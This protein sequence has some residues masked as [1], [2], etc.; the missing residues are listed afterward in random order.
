M[1][2]QWQFEGEARVCYSWGDSPTLL[3]EGS[4]PFMV[5]PGCENELEHGELFRLWKGGKQIPGK[6]RATIERLDE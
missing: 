5:M 3:I 4:A 2:K 6:W 1:S